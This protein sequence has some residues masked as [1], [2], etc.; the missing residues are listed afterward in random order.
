MHQVFT[1]PL[2]DQFRLGPQD[3]EHPVPQEYLVSRRLGNRLSNAPPLAKMGT[4]TL[5]W[6]FYNFC[7]EEAQLVA[8]KEL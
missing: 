5:F 4:G 2:G 8:A 3:I 1:G 6:V 7:Q